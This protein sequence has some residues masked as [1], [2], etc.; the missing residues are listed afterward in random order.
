APSASRC[1]ARRERR[2]AAPA[3]GRCWGRLRPRGAGDKAAP[4]VARGPSVPLRAGRAQLPARRHV[5]DCQWEG[6]ARLGC[7]QLRECAGPPPA[8]LAV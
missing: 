2:A 1:V 6:Q 7:V 8:L 5:R 4:R 3:Q